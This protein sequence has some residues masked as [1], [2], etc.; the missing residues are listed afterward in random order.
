MSMP[1]SDRRLASLLATAL[2]LS[3]CGVEPDNQ[4]LANV[5]AEQIRE[6]A[7]SGRIFCA[8]AGATAFRM[9]CSLDRVQSQDGTVLVLGRADVGYRRFRITND[10]RGVVAADGAEQSQVRVIDNGLIEVA[11]ADDR[12]RLPATIQR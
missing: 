7:Q 12:Y 1:I 9:D 4:T 6:A 3:A 8:L 10:G 11:V 5:E 2:A